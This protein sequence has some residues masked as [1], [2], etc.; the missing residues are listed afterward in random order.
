MPQHTDCS[1]LC[2]LQVVCNNV[3]HEMPEDA[4]MAAAAEFSRVLRPGGLCIISESVQLGDRP[5]LDATLG[6][7]GAMNEPHYR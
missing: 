2:T 1:A 6:A 5:Y 7:F 3:L 4:R